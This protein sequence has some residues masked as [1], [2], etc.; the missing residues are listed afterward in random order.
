MAA[1][2]SKVKDTSL[3]AQGEK[4]IRWAAAHMP[5]LAL[6]KREFEKEKPLAGITLGACLHVTKETAVLVETL[7][8]GGAAVAICGSNPLSTQDDVAA[9]LAAKPGVHVYAW[10]GVNEKEYYQCVDWT[11]DNRPDFTMDDGGDLVTRLH[12]TRQELLSHTKAGTEETTTG[13]TRFRAMAA[14]KALKYPIIAVN[15]AQTK[16]FFDNRYGT[17]QSTI[18]GLLRATSILIAGKRFVVAG[19]G[20][21]GKGL[22]TRARGMGAH[23][24]VTEVDPV[25]ALEAVMDGFTVATMKDAARTADIIITVTGG[26]HV[27]DAAALDSLKSGAIIANSG[28]FDNEIDLVHLKKTAKEVREVR[29]NVEAYT[30]KDGR[31]VYVLGEGRLLNLAAAEGHPPEVMD[32]SFANQA[33]AARYLKEGYAELAPEVYVVPKDLDDRV[34]ALK[35]EAMGVRID[36]LSDEQRRYAGAWR[37]GT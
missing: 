36:R 4:E 28:H 37:E 10:R 18:D 34:A 32:M 24:T 26:K 14:D 30:L 1:P 8:A 13:V 15:D 35:L 9:A 6:L 2:P 12:T 31:L 11:L 23:V 19:Y 29:P 5:V 20:W 25:R 17:G 33:L 7:V 22:A 16:H 27:L 21:V 3:A